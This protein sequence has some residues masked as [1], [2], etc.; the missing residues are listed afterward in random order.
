MLQ[1]KI[2][3]SYRKSYL[4]TSALFVSNM[5]TTATFLA[6]FSYAY[7]KTGSAFHTGEVTLATLLASTFL[8]PFLGLITQKRGVFVCMVIPEILSALLLI[9]IAY[10]DQIVL[11]Y[12][13]AFL[14][15]VNGK[16]VGI[17][18]MSLI[19]NVIRKDQLIRFH[20]VL[21]A[22]NRAALVIGSLVYGLIIHYSIYYIFY[23]DALTYMI[24][25][26]FLV[27]LHFQHDDWGTSSRI[28][29]KQPLGKIMYQLLEGYKILYLDPRI[30]G[31]VFL[32]ILSRFFYMSLPVLLLIMIKNDLQLSDREYGYLQAISRSLSFFV[33]V[34]LS[35]FLQKGWR[36]SQKIIILSFLIYGLGIS[37][38]SLVNDIRLVYFIFSL[39]ELFF[40]I[41]VVY[42]HAYV[43]QNITSDKMPLASGSVGTG[44]SIAS[45]GS[46]L[47]LLPLEQHLGA[48]PLLCLIGIGVCFSTFLF[49]GYRCCLARLSPA[50][51]DR[52]VR[53]Q[54]V[55]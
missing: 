43:Q 30:N 53:Q 54:D 35:E 37:T 21:R 52:D 23:F 16:L 7:A 46:L 10:L 41:A 55:G 3:S 11:V 28:S 40:F 44:F 20:A 13:A 24:S 14:L 42:I 22:T 25:A 26:V 45:I 33:F 50:E 49:C 39:A 8:G 51:M 32:G 5:G 17:S 38:V 4:L 34:F 29:E 12:P 19:P 2:D 36:Y 9:L 1:Y 6:F 47:V 18:R 15:S 27:I 48:A 31:I